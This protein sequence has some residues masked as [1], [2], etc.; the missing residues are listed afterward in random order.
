MYCSW[1]NHCLSVLSIYI[2]PTTK[3]NFKALYTVRL[4]NYREGPNK[5]SLS[6]TRW[7]WEGKISSRRSTTTE[8]KR[9][10][11]NDMQ[12]EEM[13]SAFT[14]VIH[15]SFFLSAFTVNFNF[16][17]PFFSFSSST[18]LASYSCN[19]DIF[20]VSHRTVELLNLHEAILLQLWGIH[21]IAFNLQQSLLIPWR[22][23]GRGG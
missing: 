6:S 9:H 2:E 10:K 3:I 1:F 13:S 21:H 17:S 11:V 4:Q 23:Y 22:A 15:F 7:Q 19:G 12:E 5:S 18:V 20:S 16:S 8:E 14:E